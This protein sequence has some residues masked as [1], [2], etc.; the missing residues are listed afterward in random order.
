MYITR[1]ILRSLVGI[2]LS[3]YGGASIAAS[4]GSI[5]IGGIYNSNFSA[6][7]NEEFIATLNN[8][9]TNSEIMS[10]QSVIY[11][12]SVPLKKNWLFRLQGGVQHSELIKNSLYGVL[13]NIGYMLSGSTYY[14]FSRRNMMLVSA[15]A[16]KVDYKQ[17]EGELNPGEL[18]VQDSDSVFY[19]LEF[20]QRLSF[21]TWLSERI[22]S[23]NSSFE[24]VF[25]NNT[26]IEQNDNTARGITLAVNWRA[27]K[28]FYINYG[29]SVSRLQFNDI[30]NVSRERFSINIGGS[31]K[32]STSM[33]LRGQF[34]RQKSNDFKD[35]QAI[36]GTI[37]YNSSAALTVGYQF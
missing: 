18:L 15:G 4:F 10:I 13:S 6:Y 8:S 37:I 20:K 29:T 17:N 7:L 25:V 16:R 35:Q 2:L 23:D 24:N 30:D 36:E 12:Y 1:S 32:L 3:F 11:G 27:S 34:A 5:E 28:N 31:Y 26:P 9:P 19:N 21:R 14:R 22:T 33:Y